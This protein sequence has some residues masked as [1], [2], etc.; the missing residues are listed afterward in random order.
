MADLVTHS[1]LAVILKASTRGALPAVFVLGTVLP[2]LCSRVPAISLGY[3]HVHIARL[4]SVATHG[5]QPL[6]QPLGMLLVAYLVAMMFQ[7]SARRAVFVNLLGGMALHLLVDLLQDHH[8]AGYLLGFPV[9]TGSFEFGLIGSEA[10]VW[11]AVPLAIAAWAL[12]RIR[13]RAS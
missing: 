5:W 7:E 8:G 11:W 13:R 6:H 10:T 2:D 3:V 4:P 12:T 9:W 1:A